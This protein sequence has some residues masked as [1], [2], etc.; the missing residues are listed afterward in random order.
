M[1]FE[2]R[3]QRFQS[4]TEVRCPGRSLCR[5][6]VGWTYLLNLVQLKQV[7]SIPPIYTLMMVA[8]I[9]PQEDAYGRY[10]PVKTGTNGGVLK[11][12]PSGYL[13]K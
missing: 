7:E 9:I 4:L 11:A 1:L 5:G 10:K 13:H 12:L 3:Q 8:I 2:T 6:V